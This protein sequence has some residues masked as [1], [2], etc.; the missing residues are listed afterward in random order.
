MTIDFSAL[1]KDSGISVTANVAGDVITTSFTGT[2]E[3][4]AVDA[5]NAV[6]AKLHEQ[7]VGTHVRE[8]V[9]DFTQLEFMS[10]SC[11]KALV[12][13]INDIVELPDES[14]R[15][16]LRF[17]SNPQLHWQRRSLHVLKTFATDIVFVEEV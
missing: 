10:S 14:A 8:V 7:A 12:T 9:V 16:R 6:V 3:L 5:M 4:P 11:F 17:R 2:A 1:T 13:W 15:Y